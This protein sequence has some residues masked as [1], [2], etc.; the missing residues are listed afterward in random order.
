MEIIALYK[1]IRPDGGVTVS[2][3]KPKGKYEM[4]Y[5]I[6]PDEGKALWRDGFYLH[7]CAD[8]TN[9]ADWDEVD[10]NS[11]VKQL[12]KTKYE[13]IMN[14]EKEKPFK[15][16]QD[17]EETIARLIKE[18]SELKEQLELQ[19]KQYTEQKEKTKQIEESLLNLSMNVRAEKVKQK[20]KET[21]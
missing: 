13:K 9:I 18:N 1:F 21:K 7:K 20:V 12:I 14:V 11:D 16:S 2:P 3:D 8:V 5:R 6:Y 4:M 17:V 10:E 15:P 19:Q